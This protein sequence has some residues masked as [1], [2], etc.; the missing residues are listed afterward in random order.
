MSAPEPRQHNGETPEEAQAAGREIL[1]IIGQLRQLV[2]GHERRSKIQPVKNSEMAT[3]D[4]VTHPDRLSHLT[5][6]YLNSANDHCRALLTL[7]DDGNGGLSILIVALHSH[8]RAIIEHA[9]LTSWLLS[10]S[11]PHERRRRALAAI[12]SELTF[13]KQLV[14]SI[15][16][17]RPPETREQRST[18]AKAT[19]DANRRDRTR[20]K[21][22]KAA[23][24]ACGIADDE[25]SAGLPK[26]SEILDDASTS[27]TRF[28]GGFLPKT[29]WMLTSGLTHPSA[30]RVMLVAAM[31]ETRDY[32]NG[33]LQVEVTARIGS[34]VAP[35]RT[36]T[37]MLE[38]AIDWERY[39][40][41]KVAEH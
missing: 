28:R 21:T 41:A 3:D 30:S 40:K 18:R 24:K 32:G 31:Q 5:S 29:I 36:A 22:L 9:A 6:S 23:A 25:Y 4:E 12:S 26:W 37:S 7:L 19:R 1:A 14:S 13:E 35:L 15:N 39:R 11:D 10:P 20:Q 27:S 17:G 8:I 33:T 34:L 2:D 38:D 16:Q